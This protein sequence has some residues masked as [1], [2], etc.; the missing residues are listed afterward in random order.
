MCNELLVRMIWTHAGPWREFCD[1]ESGQSGSAAAAFKKRSK[2]TIDVRSRGCA[3]YVPPPRDARRLAG[4]S[5]RAPARMQS[6]GH[7]RGYGSAPPSSWLCCLPLRLTRGCHEPPTNPPEQRSVVVGPEPAHTQPDR[8]CHS[9]RP[10]QSARRSRIV[11]TYNADRYRRVAV[12][13]VL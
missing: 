4:L 6:G 9:G 5:A 12:A 8:L 10:A 2:T 7:P 13:P 11:G 3:A 1:R